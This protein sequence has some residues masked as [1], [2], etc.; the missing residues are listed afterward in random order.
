[1]SESAVGDHWGK[2]YFDPAVHR[3]E[4]Q[5]HP[6]TQ[7]RLWTLQNGLSRDDWFATRYLNGKPAA[8]AI[9]I[10]AGRGETEI[11]LLLKGHIEHFD[12]YDVSPLGLE[13][14]KETAE[15]L[16][17][18]ER[19]T[20][21][22][23]DISK[24]YI[25]TSTYDIV[26]FAA[27]LH[28]MADLEGILW[29]LNDALTDNGMIWALNEYV[30]P[31]RFGYPEEHLALVRAFH[32]RLPARFRK[33][34]DP[35]LRVPTTAEVE[36]ADPSEAPVSSQI[37]TA[38]NAM[39]PR[40]EKLELYGSF[41]FMLFWGLNHDELYDSED[42]KELA[43]LIVDM[44]KK[45]VDLG[46]LPGYFAHIAAHKTFKTDEQRIRAAGRIVTPPMTSHLGPSALASPP[47][48][49]SVRQRKSFAERLYHSIGKRL[50]VI[51]SKQS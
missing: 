15:K 7:K 27:S 10:G 11:Q 21:H 16:G 45:L 28:H 22:C 6:A 2:Q 39:F 38:V 40:S 37:L 3:A 18:G 46:I 32:G 41:A 30:G 20:C 48:Q 50:G 26:L 24:V 33:H 34:G 49:A 44:D 14:A 23:A 36:A 51:P 1:M 42:G 19:V 31:D 12:L 5:N 47:I 4:W 35:V 17:F 13:F 25:P 8:R 43:Q 9:S 29:K